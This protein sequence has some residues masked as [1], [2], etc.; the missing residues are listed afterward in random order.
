MVVQEFETRERREIGRREA[1]SLTHTD[2]RLDCA[3]SLFPG[4]SLVAGAV[5]LPPSHLCFWSSR[6]NIPDS[7]STCV[8]PLSYMYVVTVLPLGVAKTASECFEGP[9]ALAFGS[10][11]LISPPRVPICPNTCLLKVITLLYL[12]IS[13]IACDRSSKSSVERWRM[14]SSTPVSFLDI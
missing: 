2:T 9:T 11:S 10:S 6:V 5:L 1:I 4:T 14:Q 13:S 12:L 7:W 8:L 3:L